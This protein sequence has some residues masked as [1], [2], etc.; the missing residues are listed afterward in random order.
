MSMPDP[1]GAISWPSDSCCGDSDRF[2]FICC[3]DGREP[4]VNEVW[5]LGEDGVTLEFYPTA[6]VDVGAVI[7]GDFATHYIN[8]N[9]RSLM[10]VLS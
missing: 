1:V 5:I 4:E 3:V 8:E 2:H 9:R 6:Q 10:E 7:V